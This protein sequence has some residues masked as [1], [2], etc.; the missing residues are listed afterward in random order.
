MTNFNSRTT[1]KMTKTFIIGPRTII[2]NKKQKTK[3][4]KLTNLKRRGQRSFFLE[5]REKKEEKKQS[6]ARKRTQQCIQ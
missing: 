5:E 2:K 3:G 6:P 1:L 4:L